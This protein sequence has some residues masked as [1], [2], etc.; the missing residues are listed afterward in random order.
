MKREAQQAAFIFAAGF[1]IAGFD[2]EKFPRVAAVTAF[3]EDQDFS[4]LIDDEQPA[5][6]VRRFGHPNGTLVGKLGKNGLERD[7]RERLRVGE[8][9]RDA[10][11]QRQ[12]KRI[13]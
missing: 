6:A 5:R 1:G 3:P 8:Q 4:G 13:Q 9:R 10:G 12:Q 7:F 2:V 11:A